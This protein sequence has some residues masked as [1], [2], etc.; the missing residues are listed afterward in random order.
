MQKKIENGKLFSIPPSMATMFLDDPGSLSTAVTRLI[1]PCLLCAACVMPTS[2][3][4]DVRPLD[5]P[6]ITATHHPILFSQN[7]FTSSR[8]ALPSCRSP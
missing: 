6:L 3:Q 5:G 8:A 2:S 4:N 7:T 1:N